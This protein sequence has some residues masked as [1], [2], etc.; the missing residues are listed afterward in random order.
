MRKMIGEA[1]VEAGLITNEQLENALT[2]RKGKNKRLGKIL[3][4]LGYTTEIQIA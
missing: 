4:E 3:L 2:L 1:L